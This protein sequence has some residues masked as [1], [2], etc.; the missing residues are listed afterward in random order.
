M[1]T[2]SQTIRRLSAVATTPE[3]TRPVA[4][5]TTRRSSLQIALLCLG[6]LFC[7][8]GTSSAQLVVDYNFATSAT[9]PDGSGQYT[10]TRTLGGWTSYSNIT[11]SLSLSSPD[12]NNPMFLGD[13]YSTL[14][15]G[16]PS[17][18][19]R[20]AVLLNR[21]GRNT[22]NTFGSSL[23]SLS[24]TLDDSAAH[25]NI[26]DTTSST[27]TYNSDGRLGVDPYGAPVNGGTRGNTLTG[28]NGTAFTSNKFTLLMADTDAG[29][30]ARL[31]SWGITITGTA[32]ST[33]TMTGSGGTFAI[34]DTGSGAVNDLGAALVITQAGGGPLNV[35]LAGTT[36]FSGVV[37]GT[38]GITKQ[39]TGTLIL[40]NANTYSGTTAVNAGTLLAT[41]TTGS[42][43]STGA[44][45]V[46]GSGTI[47]GGTGII[48]GSVTLGNT[49]PGAI[50]NPGPAGANGTAASVGTL[51]VGA[52][53]LTGANT[54]HIDAFGTGAGEWDK[55][56]ANGVILGTTSTLQLSIAGSLT[57]TPGTEYVVISNTSGGIS[58]AFSGIVEGGTYTFDGYDFTA[59]YMGGDGNDFTLTTPVPEPA[60][61]L[62]A[63]VALIAVA[64]TQLRKRSACESLR[65]SRAG[66]RGRI[67]NH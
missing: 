10:N 53:T 36:T 34:S 21:P 55:L 52:L 41:N 40:S 27:G 32:A 57:F 37:S 28:L 56:I 64:F 33:G 4:S 13:M 58:G 46:N 60:T 59:S 67:T 61:W 30:Q 24:V 45:T 54:L 15:V 35:T 6:F 1:R 16:L 47:L 63:A 7:A 44:V 48:T 39:G 2:L 5:R 9:I 23:S 65:N 42:A 49:T 14:T 12:V 18:T 43:T 29:G 26:F 62:A 19:P 25:T 31:D 11:V 51:T 3:G 20:T 38:G 8:A 66:A 50:V 22:S 17:E